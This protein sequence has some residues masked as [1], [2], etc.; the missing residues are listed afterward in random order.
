MLFYEPKDG[1]FR[2]R[3]LN[4]VALLVIT[5]GIVLVIGRYRNVFLSKLLIDDENTIYQRVARARGRSAYLSNINITSIRDVLFYSPIKTLYFLLSPV[6]WNW[7]H[8]S[9]IISFVLDSSVY[10]YLISKWIRV[11][12]LKGKKPV[13]WGMSISCISSLLIFALSCGNSGTAV[14]HRFKLLGILIVIACI[15]KAQKNRMDN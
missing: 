1:K 2:F 10:L 9:D 6:P 7:R 8:A 5:V 3:R 4:I 11:F 15:I 14:R 12:S 13:I